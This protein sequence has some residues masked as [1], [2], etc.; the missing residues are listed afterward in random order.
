MFVRYRT[1]LLL[2]WLVTLQFPR[3]M[4]NAPINVLLDKL[5]LAERR[6]LL[7]LFEPVALPLRHVLYQPE[8][9]P[10]YVHFLT[11]G[12]ASIVTNMEDGQISECGLVGCEGM[13]ESLHLIGPALVHTS[14]FMQIRGTALRM[15]F[16][17]FQEQ[18]LRLPTLRGSVLA[19]VQYQSLV[20]G[21]VAACNRLHNVEAR[22]ARWLLMVSDRTDEHELPLSQEFLAQMLGSQRSTITNA[23]GKLQSEGAIEY[24]RGTV[25]ILDRLKLEGVAC[26]CYNV[27]ATI[28]RRFREY[29]AQPNSEQRMA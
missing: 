26:E 11:S 17:A 4:G 24:S 12:M 21:Q 13:P 1:I 28:L 3:T 2:K 10:P 5:P 20:L 23:A 29:Q 15:R 9:E 14:C 6:P 19:F 18:M 25:C 16:K 8:Q 27:T 7:S 22:L